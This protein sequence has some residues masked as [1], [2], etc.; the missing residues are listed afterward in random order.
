MLLVRRANVKLS[1]PFNT[2]ALDCCLLMALAAILI[3]RLRCDQIHRKAE[4]VS[5]NFCM[6]EFQ[7]CHFG[8]WSKDQFSQ[9]TQGCPEQDSSSTINFKKP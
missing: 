5:Y 7:S 1:P 8:L 4:R 3:T 6:Q 2:Y 9:A